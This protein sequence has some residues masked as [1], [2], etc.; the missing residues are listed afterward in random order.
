MPR[1][2]SICAT[3]SSSLQDKLG[4]TTIMVTHDQEEALAMADRIVVMNVTAFIEQ[5]G[6][7]H[8]EIYANPASPFVADFIGTTNFIDGEVTG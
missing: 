1:C 7:P 5:I 6:T 4:I 2:A 8:R 3:R